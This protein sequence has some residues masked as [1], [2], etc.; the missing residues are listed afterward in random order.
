MHRRHPDCNVLADT[1]TVNKDFIPNSASTVSVSLSCTSGTV[2]ATPLDASESV[3]AVFNLIGANPGTTCVATEAVPAGYVANQTDCL[4]VAPNGSCT[5][6][7]TQ[8]TIATS[9]A[10]PANSYGFLL[11]LAGLL[12]VVG[13]AAKRR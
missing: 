13:L 10:V 4:S 8:A 2:A 1:I 6:T 9:I 7:N 12:T 5:I 11:L 3:P